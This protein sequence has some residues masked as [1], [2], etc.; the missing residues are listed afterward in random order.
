MRRFLFTLTPLAVM[1]AAALMISAQAPQGKDGGKGGGKAG[2][3]DGGKGGAKDG[4]K[5]GG[6]AAAA[7]PAIVQIKPNLYEVTGLGGNTTVRVTNAGLLIVDTKNLGQANYDQ[8]MTLIKTVSTQPP[9]FGVITH[10]HQDHSGNTGLLIAAG[11][12]VYANEGE[13]AELTTYNPAQG[14]PAAPSKTYKKDTTIK[15]GGATAKLYHFG[16]AHTGGDTVV[17]FPDLK[18]VAGGDA[19]PNGMP[20]CDLPNGGSVVNWPKFVAEVL[21]LDFDT[22]IPGHGDVM[23][24]AQVVEYQK[25][26]ATFASRAIAEVKKGTPKDQ[27]LAA[28]KVDDIGW[29]TASYAAAPAA[30]QPSRLDLLYAE[31]KKAK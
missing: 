2:A 22:L 18:V 5:G 10:V 7:P 23:T 16:A 31:L 15:L 11:A 3:K 1:V 8:L 28:I 14:K 9:K 27:L 21:K 26:W 17:Y 25:K 12:E 6:K 30:G 19:I 4:G 13:K 29:T 24:R 20:N